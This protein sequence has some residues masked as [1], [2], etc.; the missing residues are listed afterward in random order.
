MTPSKYGV[1][2]IRAPDIFFGVAALLLATLGEPC[3][4]ERVRC[5]RFGK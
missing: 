5:F 2:I 4:R 3:R 1:M